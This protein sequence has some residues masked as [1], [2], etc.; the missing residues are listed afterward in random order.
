LVWL[1]PL[2][3]MWSHAGQAKSLRRFHHVTNFKAIEPIAAL[4]AVKAI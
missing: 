2:F 3:V 4:I 1:H